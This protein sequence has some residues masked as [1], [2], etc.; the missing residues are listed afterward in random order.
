MGLQSRWQHANRYNDPLAVIAAS[1]VLATL[2]VRRESRTAQPML[3]LSLF[4][5]RLFTL[6]TRSSVFSSTSRSTA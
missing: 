6:T 4:G 3:P 5:H 2:L 1:A